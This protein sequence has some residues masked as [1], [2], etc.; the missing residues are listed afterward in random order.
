M[1]VNRFSIVLFFMLII[2][3]AKSNLSPKEMI[4]WIE[5]KENGLIKEET[6]DGAKYTVSLHPSQYMKARAI[7]ENDSFMLANCNDQNCSVVVKMEPTDKH[8]QFLTLGAI[9]N[10]EP[11]GRINYYLNGIQNDIKVLNGAD[12]LK[13]E[14]LIYER[15]YNVSPA[16]LILFGFKAKDINQSI[17]VIIEDRAINS[18]KMQFEYSSKILSSIPNIKE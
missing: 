5:N 8:T 17:K 2:G 6:I 7:I 14:N 10:Q 9:N 3:C 12:T 4:K 18:G 11:F 16:Q 1:Q 13:V 15:L